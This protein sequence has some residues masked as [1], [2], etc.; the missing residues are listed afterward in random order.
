MGNI[1]LKIDNDMNY[2]NLQKKK[3]NKYSNYRCILVKSIFSRIYDKVLKN[4]IEEEYRNSELKE[5]S[6]FRV[7]RSCIDNIFP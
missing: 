5:Q 1:F 2:P 3:K 4:V 7:A 6:E